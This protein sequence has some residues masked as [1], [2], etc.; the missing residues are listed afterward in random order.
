MRRCSGA[1]RR[2]AGFGL[3]YF[4]DD[5]TARR[6]G[7]RRRHRSS[8]RGTA[9]AVRRPVARL[10]AR[11]AA[12][13]RSRAGISS[14]TPRSTTARRRFMA[15]TGATLVV[16]TYEDAA[17]LGLSPQSLDF[18]GLV[19]DRQRRRPAW[20]PSRSTA[21]GST[22]SPCATSL[23]R[24]REGRACHQPARHE[25]LE[26]A[27]SASRCR[28]TSWCSCNRTTPSGTGARCSLLVSRPKSPMQGSMFP[29]PRQDLDPQH[30]RVRAPALRQGDRISRI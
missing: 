17:R 14:S 22:T 5:I 21:C 12:Q 28:G 7:S 24:R 9:R 16:L 4:F 11:G 8:H 10:R 3:F 27:E 29:K 23:R 30:R 25:L 26:P 13:S 19:P 20:R 6:F 18:S 1:R 2:S 15:D